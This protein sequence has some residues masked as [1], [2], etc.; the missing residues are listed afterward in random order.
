MTAKRVV[1]G[2]VLFALAALFATVSEASVLGIDLSAEFIK[3]ASV[4]PKNPF[5]I[6]VDEQAKRK[7]PLAV[8][9]DDG[10]RHFGNN[11]VGF[12]LRKPLDTYLWSHRL[13]GKTLDSP[14]VAELKSMFGY[15]FVTIPG[16]GGSV[17]IKMPKSD[18]ILSPEELVAMSLQHI[19]KI[20]KDDSGVESRD[21][22]LSVPAWLGQKERQAVLDAA[23]LAGLNVM[24]LINDN[25]ASAITYGVDRTYDNSTHR[26]LFIDIG[27]AGMEATLVQYTG[28]K[29]GSGKSAKYVGQTLVLGS[30]WDESLGG[31]AF[32]RVIRDELLRQF[33]AKG[34]AKVAGV[35]TNP[36]AMAK[37]LKQATT[38]KTV[39]S[40]N[41]EIPVK[42]ENVF[43]DQDLFTSISRTQFLELAA[44]LIARVPGP[45]TAVLAK[46][47]VA[48]ADVDAVVIVGGSVRIPAVQ[49][50][51]RAAVAKDKLD[52]SINGDEA[53][54]MGA[55]FRAANVSGLFQVRPFGVADVTAFPVSV[56]ITDLNADAAAGS[57]AAAAASSDDGEGAAFEKNVSLF[58]H[59][60]LLG[61]KKTIALT[62]T[63]DLLVKLTTDASLLPAGTTPA[64]ITYNV[65]GVAALADT[66]AYAALMAAGQKPRVA[67]SF[68]LSDSGIAALVGAEATLDEMVSVPKPRAAKKDSKKGKKTDKDGKEGADVAAGTEG[69]EAKKDDDKATDAAAAEED[70]KDQ[71]EDAKEDADAPVEFIQQKKTHRVALTVAVVAG[72]AAGTAFVPLNAATK[73]TSRAFLDSLT[74][75]DAARRALA[76]ARN[77]L[78]S[79]YYAVR[80]EADDDAALA[81]VT[82]P[83]QRAEMT[84]ASRAAEEWLDSEEGY[85]AETAAVTAQVQ[86]LLAVVKDA[87]ARRSE[88]AA[89]GPA[90][91]AAWA[92][93]DAARAKVSA[94]GLHKQWLPA[95]DV[96][97]VEKDAE[98]LELWLAE[99][100][101]AQEAA[102]AHEA[103]VFLASE[104]VSKAKAVT[105]AVAR[106]DRKKK[107]AEPKAAKN[108]TDAN[109]TDAGTNGTAEAGAEGESEAATAEVKAD[110]EPAAAAEGEAAAEK[111]ATEEGKKEEK[112]ETAKPKDE[113]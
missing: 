25:T 93:A 23:E 49:A 29:V 106:V 36:R 9:F 8:A 4:R 111:P 40:A 97:A 103:P 55:V 48:A 26:A 2:L 10:E 11:A 37:L 3:V 7:I 13:L 33:Q 18:V 80:N 31:A 78:E 50:A 6:V 58:A 90:V 54:A 44:P 99:K 67:L 84:K 53:M 68:V 98:A 34:G 77:D 62:H 107:P 109:A 74:A 19:R 104:A 52:Q 45:I 1:F 112:K 73:Q 30:A 22:V 15:E 66:P 91:A 110:A 51:I 42:V 72:D 79:L 39:L 87:R 75:R 86:A 94:W 56:T 88:A 41:N 17:G 102:A 16:R 12:A 76:A 69:E 14:Q 63:S 61:K 100:T 70:K 82:T 92:A 47:G 32:D 57:A 71:E 20:A 64:L 60:N 24:T 108:A 38:V 101:K 46:A 35:E 96:E 27:S 21:A 5:H 81:A 65:S 95:A 43:K 83:E 85:G 28:R 89:R 105:A 113:L 59:H